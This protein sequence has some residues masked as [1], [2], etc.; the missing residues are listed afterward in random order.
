MPNAQDFRNK[1]NS[2]LA[3]FSPGQRVVVGIAVV[4]LVV[5]GIFFAQW[6]SKPNM[7]PLFSNLSSDD[8]ASITSKLQSS[9][10]SYKLADGGNTIMVAQSQVYQTRL[11][12]ASA[13][14]PNGGNSGYTLLDKQGITT[15]DFIEHVDYQRALEGELAKTIQS[16]Q[17]VD[18]AS[19]N[20]VIPQSDVF[21]GDSQKPTASVLVKTTGGQQLTN[22]QVTS[23]INLVGGAVEGLDP[24]NVSVTDD[25][26]RNL[27]TAGQGV[28]GGAGD[29]SDQSATTNA[30]ESDLNSKIQA[31]LTPVLGSGKAVVQTNADLNWDKVSQTSEIYNPDNRPVTPLSQSTQTE[32]YN[33]SGAGT[34]ATGCLG[35][36][37]TV[38]SNTCVNGNTSGT[39]SST[40]YSSQNNTQDN[41]VDKTVKQTETTPGS[42]N[43]LSVA[44]LLDSNVPNVDVAQVQ[45]LV[46]QAAGL[47]S[48]RGDTVSISK[49]P[50]DS[51]QANSDKAALQA[52]NKAKQSQ[53][54]MGLIKTGGTVAIILMVLGML[55]FLTKKRAQNFN[56]MPL[57]MAELDAAMPALPSADDLMTEV[58]VDDNT[59]EALERK[60]V[61]KEITDLIDKQPDEVASLLRSWLAD[62]RS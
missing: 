57:S 33:G 7:V 36:G 42:I 30:L 19:V 59:P 34:A 25:K 12:M 26:G 56:S 54:T 4:T 18:A 45:Q 41:G 58:H 39:G 13:G 32:S 31:L 60:K 49:M 21:S 15:S 43:R 47:Q 61:D 51:T 50:F 6:A 62:R 8:A 48:A 17:G 35:A 28:N 9:H 40:P 5:G 55:W 11:D 10:V 14:L 3:G 23:I 38:T 46:T 1:A 2:M 37:V 27:A 53:Q 52:A 24:K 20:L 22:Q 44:V 16:I 29:G